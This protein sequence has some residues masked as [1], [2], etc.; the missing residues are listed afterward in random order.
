MGRRN[1]QLRER[2]GQPYVTILVAWFGGA[3][4][5]ISAESTYQDV[6]DAEMQSR[7]P[8][9]QVHMGSTCF[10]IAAFV[11]LLFLLTVLETKS[12]AVAWRASWPWL[13]IMGLTAFAT[14][15]RVPL[16]VLL[17]AWAI[18]SVWAYRRTRE[19]D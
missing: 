5:C 15:I 4:A 10:G 1:K 9:W 19:K 14:L 13:P 2:R 17:P 8:G 11:A 18:N 7:L 3:C 6:L 16:Y 12:R